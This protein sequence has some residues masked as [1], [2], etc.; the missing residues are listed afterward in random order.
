MKCPFAKSLGERGKGVHQ[1]RILGFALND[2][3]GTIIGAFIISYLFNYDFN[4]TLLW[5]FI[6]GEFL[7][8]I[9]GVDTAFLEL[10]GLRSDC[11]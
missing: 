9:L 1:A 8:F 6:L 10:I 11:N 3:L 7:H 5:L 4:K 2:I